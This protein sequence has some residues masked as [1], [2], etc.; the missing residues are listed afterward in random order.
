MSIRPAVAADIPAL[1]LLMQGFNEGE[2]YPFDADRTR[3]LLTWFV[4]DARLGRVWIVVEDGEAVGYAVLALGFSF[5]FG[6]RDAFVDELY[7]APSHRGRGLGGRALET[8][9]QG[10]RE[11]GVATLHLEAERDKDAT[12]DMYRRHGFADNGRRLL[13][14]RLRPVPGEPTTA[15]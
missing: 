8:A 13:S 2:G 15:G 4:A 5:E 7:V 1:V 11:M 12:L 14:K 6:G 9:I 3:G 10:C